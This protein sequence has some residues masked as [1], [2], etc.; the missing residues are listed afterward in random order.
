MKNRII[1][2]LIFFLTTLI[3]GMYIIIDNGVH[4]Q[5]K[6]M[7]LLPVVYGLLQF[8]CN[9]S[10]LVSQNIGISLIN[11]CMLIRY[12]LSPL[13]MAISGKYNVLSDYGVYLSTSDINKAVYLM[14]YEMIVVFLVIQFSSKDEKKLLD[15]KDSSKIHV[16]IDRTKTNV[17]WGVIICSVVFIIIF[18]DIIQKFTFAFNFKDISLIK[19]CSNINFELFFTLLVQWS[20]SFLT[21]IIIQRMYFRYQISKHMRIIYYSLLVV[22][23]FSSLI[24]YSS[25]FSI[26]VPALA[27][28]MLIRQIY[29]EKARIAIKVGGL[30]LFLCLILITLTKQYQ[31]NSVLAAKDY[32]REIVGSASK[33]LQVYFSGITDVAISVQAKDN[34]GTLINITT[35]LKDI[36]EPIPIIH[37]LIPDSTYSSSNIFNYAIYQNFDR[38]SYIVPLIGQG[39]MIFGEIGA[40]L[41][42]FIVTLA[43]VKFAERSNSDRNIF[44]KYIQLYL[45]VRLGLFMMISLASLISTVVNYYFLVYIIILLNE[46]VNTR[47]HS[48]KTKYSNEVFKN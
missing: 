4:S 25:R 33:M 19:H 40:P 22:L 13:I 9:K 14:I 48:L 28:M 35:I 20:M 36:I 17:F 29:G 16:S 44:K 12:L 15:F 5:Y 47:K 24:L 8:C 3:I 23:M 6:V 39:Y 30:V 46:L 43:A 1:Y 41:F 7:A 26:L 10:S 32:F 45:T 37:N 31:I 27:G 11:W 21:V 34:Y 2:K 38:S 18:P 42:S